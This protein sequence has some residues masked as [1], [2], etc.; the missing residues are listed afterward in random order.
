MCDCDVGEMFLNF[1]LHPDI[2]SHAWV[3]ETNFYPEEL[4]NKS[5]SVKDRWERMMMGYSP[6]PY[7]VTKD[8]LIVENITKGCRFNGDNVYRWKKV[9]F[10]LPGMESCDPT[11]S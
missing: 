10:N 7:V 9:I 6:S 11:L 1:M 4:V 8:I 5:R 3:D 2:R